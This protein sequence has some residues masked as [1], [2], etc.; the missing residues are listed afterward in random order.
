MKD[1]RTSEEFIKLVEISLVQYLYI[2]LPT[3]IIH[4]THIYIYT[5]CDEYFNIGILNL[6]S[7]LNHGYW[8]RK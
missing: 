2:L 3:Y 8:I 7:C 6:Y 5:S 1:R 4:S